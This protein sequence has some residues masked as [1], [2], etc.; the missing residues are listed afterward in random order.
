VSGSEPPPAPDWQLRLAALPTAPGLARAFVTQT[1]RRWS[2]SRDCSETA[3]LLVSE[4]VTNAVRRT[5]RA[6][7]PAMPYPTE[8]VVVVG[9]RV[10]LRSD[11]V[12][13]EV[14]DRD[15][16]PPVPAEP[17]VKDESGR[18]LHIV[19]ALSEAWGVRSSRAGGKVV[20]C[21]VARAEK[22]TPTQRLVPAPLPKRQPQRPIRSGHSSTAQLKPDIAMLEQVI[23]GL[24]RAR[25]G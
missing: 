25:T 24:R 2:V 18:G 14:W 11:V 19:G 23:W 4:L 16:T 5:G 1:L 13:L 17:T 21:D 10:S 22:T 8:T 7:G 6:D 3:E 9:V 20:W 12:R 15:P